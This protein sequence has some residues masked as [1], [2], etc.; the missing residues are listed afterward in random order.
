MTTRAGR[1]PRGEAEPSPSPRRALV[2]QIVL[3]ED[4]GFDPRDLAGPILLRG[5]DDQAGRFAVYATLHDKI[6][7][8]ISDD[9]PPLRVSLGAIAEAM[10]TAG[11]VRA[12][13]RGG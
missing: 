2:G 6:I 12:R 10:M 7:T 8:I 11:S 5:L 3:E 4:P 13:R 9:R 1:R